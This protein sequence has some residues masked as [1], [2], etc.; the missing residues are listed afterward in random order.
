M[1]PAATKKTAPARAAV[2]APAGQESTPHHAMPD[3]VAR[4]QTLEWDPD[5]LRK[6]LAD[7]TVAA[8]DRVGPVAQSAP[9]AEPVAPPA[10]PP[11][12]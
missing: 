10:E 11:A 1:K 3:L 9:A 8:L 4:A 7:L 2:V 6:F 5:V 12:S